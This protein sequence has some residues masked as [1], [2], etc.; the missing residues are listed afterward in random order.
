MDAHPSPQLGSQSDH[1]TRRNQTSQS[2]TRSGYP[3]WLETPIESALLSA[4]GGSYWRILTDIVRALPFQPNLEVMVFVDQVEEPG[5]KLGTLLTRQAVDVFHMPSNGEYA[6][7]S[8]DR[9]GADDGM[10]GFELAANVFWRASLFVVQ[11]ESSTFSDFPE[12]RL[13]E[14][15]SQALKELLIGLADAI[16]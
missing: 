14:S 15:G 1:H 10:N 6:L 2:G 7:P 16:I 12:A 11:L 5:Q 3:R 9:V 8:R 13:L 4:G